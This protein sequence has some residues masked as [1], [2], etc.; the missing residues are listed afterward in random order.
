MH[1]RLGST[2]GIFVF[3]LSEFVQVL[4]FK[5][6]TTR[7]QCRTTFNLAPCKPPQIFS[8]GW[9]KIVVIID[10]HSIRCDSGRNAVTDRSGA[11]SHAAETNRSSN[12]VETGKQ[13]I[14]G[15]DDMMRAPHS[16]CWRFVG[17]TLCV[18][19]LASV[20]TAVWRPTWWTVWR[21]W[22]GFWWTWLDGRCTGPWCSSCTCKQKRERLFQ[23]VFLSFY[24]TSS[25]IIR[26]TFH[27]VFMSFDS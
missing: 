17:V 27:L 18:W 5:Y 2:F 15:A 25:K 20:N 8:S 19:Q 21:G 24:F 11:V 1:K 22:A 13:C 26:D 3:W 12:S 23:L 6:L 9:K 14:E 16:D 10:L 7:W 4:Q